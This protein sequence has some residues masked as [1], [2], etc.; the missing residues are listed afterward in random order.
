VLDLPRLPIKEANPREQNTNRRV[1]K[2]VAKSLRNEDGAPNT[3]LVKNLGIYACAKAIEKVSDDEYEG[4]DNYNE[5]FAQSMTPLAREAV[6]RLWSG[7]KRAGGGRTS[8][9]SLRRRANAS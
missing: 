9:R 3:F 8:S 2:D 7:L 5:Y 4:A 6:Q 1:Y